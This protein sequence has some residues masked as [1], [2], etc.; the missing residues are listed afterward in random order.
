MNETDRLVAALDAAPD[1][2]ARAALLAGCPKNLLAQLNAALVYR[3]FI[4]ES[5]AAV[6][7]EKAAFEA[8]TT[9]LDAQPDDAA[10]LLII[11][12]A[13][14]D[15]QRGAAWLAEWHWQRTATTQDWCERYLA[16][17]RG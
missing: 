13:R 16:M 3:R 11:E 10:R 1:D 6:A 2:A 12:A 15:P 4:A 14:R 17:V 5:D 8:F 7:A 9:E